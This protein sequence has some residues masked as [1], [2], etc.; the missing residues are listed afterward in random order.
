MKAVPTEAGTR[1]T[2]WVCVQTG[3]PH[4]SATFPLPVPDKVTEP[5]V[6]KLDPEIVKSNPEVGPFVGLRA[7]M[8]GA[9]YEKAASFVTERV[10]VLP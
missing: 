4:T 1:H 9:E 2:I 7:V 3:L 5:L 8:D 6:S 10:G